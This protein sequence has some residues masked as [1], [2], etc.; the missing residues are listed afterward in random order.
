MGGEVSLHRTLVAAGRPALVLTRTFDPYEVAGIRVEQI[1]TDDVLNVNADPAPIAQQLR[2]VGASV[3][4]AQNELSLPAVKAAKQLGIPSIVSVHTPPKYGAGIRQA[5]QLAD[6][7][8][9][10]T[11]ASMVEWRRP[12]LVLHPPVPVLPAVTTLL[13][14]DAYTL[15]SNLANKGVTI[16]LDLAARMPG[17]RF[18]IVRSPAEPTH[19]IP[20][21]DER[22]AALPNV[23][24]G[25][26]VAPDEVAARYLSQTRILLVPSRME[27][28]GMSAIEAAGH[29]IPTVHVDTAHVREGIGDAAELVAPLHT[30]QTEAALHRIEGD[31]LRR[32]RLAHAR[33]VYLAVRQEVEL[34]SWAAWIGGL[35]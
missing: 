15:L 22:C 29:G 11:H 28:Y 5:I 21:F 34:D 32:S 23:E 3:V 16:A 2:D 9:Y 7:R 17:Q 24:I 14:G 33:A 31:Y 4:L 19:G 27:T 30:D 26:R 18:I 12:G 8:I 25:E 13:R 10:N 1:A 35:A 6:H 20:D